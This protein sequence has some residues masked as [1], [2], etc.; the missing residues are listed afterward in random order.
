VAF[1]PD[2]HTLV[3]G[4][5]DQTI[6]QWETDPEQVTSQICAVAYPRITPDQWEQ[7]LPDIDYRPPCT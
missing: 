4:S 6:R 5:A 7:Y 3:T 2:G 1:H